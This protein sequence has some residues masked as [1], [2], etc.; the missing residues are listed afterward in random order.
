M[1]QIVKNLPAVG[2]TLVQ[3]LS[4]E[5]PLAKGMAIH[6]CILAQRILWILSKIFYGSEKKKV[7]ISGHKQ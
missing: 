4:R 1:A 2:E 3:S 5:D 6:S 7:F